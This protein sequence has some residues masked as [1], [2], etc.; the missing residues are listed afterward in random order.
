MRRMGVLGWAA[1]VVLVSALLLWTFGI[2]IRATTATGDELSQLGV[3]A[4]ILVAPLTAVGTL[5]G[6]LALVVAVRGGGADESDKAAHRL[7]ERVVEQRKLFLRMALGV[8]Y[9]AKPAD[10]TFDHPSVGD[11]PRAAEGLL[12]HWQ[13]LA[14]RGD[15][16]QGTLATIGAFYTTLPE[17]HSGRLVILGEPGAGKSVLASQLTLDLA[18][19]VAAGGSGKGIRAPVWLSLTGCPLTA[20]MSPSAADRAYGKWITAEI[21]GGYGLSRDAAKRLV[22]DSRFLPVLDGLDEMDPLGAAALL[23]HLNRDR[24]LHQPVILACRASD[25]GDLTDHSTPPMILRDARHTS[26]LPLTPHAISDYLRWISRGNETAWRSVIEAVENPLPASE[27]GS[28]LGLVLANP[29]VLSFAMI[30]FRDDPDPEALL[31]LEPETALADLVGYTIPAL[32]GAPTLSDGRNVTDTYGWTGERLLLWLSHL[33]HTQHV[34]HRKD[35]SEHD[36]YLPDLWALSDARWVRWIPSATLLLAPGLASIALNVLI[37]QPWLSVTW[38]LL[39]LLGFTAWGPTDVVRADLPPKPRTFLSGLAE[40]LVLG[41]LG[42]LVV[43]VGLALAGGLVVG[44]AFSL[45]FGLAGLLVGL[46][47]FGLVFVLTGK[48]SGRRGRRDG[49]P[50]PL[51]RWQEYGLSVGMVLGSAIG[52]V[53]WFVFVLVG[54]PVFGFVFGLA[55]LLAGGLVLGPM[56]GLAGEPAG[57]MGSKQLLRQCLAGGLVFGLP[58]GLAGGLVGWRAGGRADVWGGGLADGWEWPWLVALR[59]WSVAGRASWPGAHRLTRFLDWGLSVG[60]F[61][62]AGYRLQFRHREF[63]VELLKLYSASPKNRSAEGERPLR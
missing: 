34:H 12:V 27:G 48:P 55:G 17:A 61:R 8:T 36:I 9:T 32:A 53:P 35:A 20:E 46:L 30:A 41:L 42:G 21:R 18:K 6:L 3:W 1:T 59:T 58:G 15:P 28:S 16:G 54:L 47:V 5:V 19:V 14:V 38:V 33:A 26:V 4:S 31:A 49:G 37:H 56:F 44:V 50:Q 29:L 51:P 13:D 39:I 2:A 43:G 11:L 63:S 22:H 40:G 7:A 10:L 60:L 57:T 62:L 25:Y 45:V 24:N 23:E 52:F